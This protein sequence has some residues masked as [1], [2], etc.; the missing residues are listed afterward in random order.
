MSFADRLLH[1]VRAKENPTVVGLDAHLALVPAEFSAV[2]DPSATRAEVA[3]AVGDFLDQV[4]D[5]TADVVP[6][7]KPQS[8]FFEELG[9]DGAALWERV[10]ARAHDAGLLVVGDVK[11]GDIASTAAAYA[12]A[13]LTGGPDADARQPV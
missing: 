5:A 13:F 6:A 11:R 3:A 7:V 12:H 10:V 2:H 9:A 4:L 8:A 1:A